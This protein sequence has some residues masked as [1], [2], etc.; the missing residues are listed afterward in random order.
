MVFLA[1]LETNNHGSFP[2]IFESLLLLIYALNITRNGNFE[3]TFPT[4][5]SFIENYLA[6]NVEEQPTEWYHVAFT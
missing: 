4:I 5:I 6:E 2:L 1:I 3:P